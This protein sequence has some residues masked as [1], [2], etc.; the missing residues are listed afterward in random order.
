MLR[1]QIASI[2]SPAI[3]CRR[4]AGPEELAVRMPHQTT[5]TDLSNIA[6]LVLRTSSPC[7]AGPH[8]P[9]FRQTLLSLLSTHCLHC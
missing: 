9:L 8:G 1:L 5:S 6:A 3:D 4:F 2:P 7:C